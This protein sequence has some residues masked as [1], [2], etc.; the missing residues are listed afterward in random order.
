ML[1]TERC[2]DFESGESASTYIDGTLVARGVGNGGSDMD[3]KY[4]TEDED[5]GE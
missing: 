1:A 3:T 4:M 2:I 5:Y